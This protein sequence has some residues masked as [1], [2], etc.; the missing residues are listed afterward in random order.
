MNIIQGA[1][2]LLV[3]GRAAAADVDASSRLRV[4]GN[5]VVPGA[6]R[7][8]WG[9]DDG[10]NFHQKECD[11]GSCVLK[12]FGSCPEDEDN[13][14]SQEMTIADSIEG[15]DGITRLLNIDV[16]SYMDVVELQNLELRDE[17]Y[18]DAVIKCWDLVG[19]DWAGSAPINPPSTSLLKGQRAGAAAAVM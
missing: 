19:V 15:R 18:L 13:D 9:G 17:N 16:V 5:K 4:S 11:D 10:C 8:D 2:T 3:L 6:L 14:E 12:L 7:D 1:L